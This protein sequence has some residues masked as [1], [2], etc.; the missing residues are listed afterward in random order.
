MALAA[1]TQNTRQQLEEALIKRADA[2]VERMVNDATS[3]IPDAVERKSKR[4]AEIVKDRAFPMAR[5]REV[6]ERCKQLLRQ[7]YEMSVNLYLDDAVTA[8]RNADDE[9]KNMLIGKAKDHFSLALRAGADEDFKAA[10]RRKLDQIALTGPVGTSEK[11]KQA[12]AAEAARPQ[13]HSKAPGG[14]EKR[15]CIRYNDPMI[16]VTIAGRKYCT[17]NWSIR[18]LLIEAYRGTLAVGD[19]ITIGVAWEGSNEV[20]L[21][22]ARVVRR[23][24]E[25]ALLAVELNGI[26][27]NM[28]RLA[29]LMRLKDVAPMP[30]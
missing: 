10:V 12:A 4:V 20:G 29:H 13:P 7:A 16:T 28:L 17:R 1:T 18:G 30:E 24:E 9:R 5:R 22:P 6:Q 14:V 3:G 23:D 21:S 25:A 2:E 15:R 11:A 8:V 27:G 19:R 26:D